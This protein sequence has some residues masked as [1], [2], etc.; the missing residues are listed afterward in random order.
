MGDTPAFSLQ[1]NRVLETEGEAVN[2]GWWL[3]ECEQII[4]E[5]MQRRT[6][7]LNLSKQHQKKS[8]RLLW[9]R[10]PDKV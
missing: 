4:R 2:V 8:H 9:E 3:W 7:S 5:E 10:P 6:I 1:V